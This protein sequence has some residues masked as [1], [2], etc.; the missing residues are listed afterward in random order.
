[1]NVTI[2]ENAYKQ[3][4][5]SLQ[6]QNLTPDDAGL[7]LEVLPGGCAG[8]KVA[9]SL[10]KYEEL[11]KDDEIYGTMVGIDVF[12]DP[13]SAQYLDGLTIDFVET[14]AGAGFKLEAP[15]LGSGCGCGLSFS[16]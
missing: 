14:F 15:N 6:S 3:L 2:T 8:L 1:M 4:M 11:Q 10:E 5:K 7:R 16:G 12:V 9:P 13:F